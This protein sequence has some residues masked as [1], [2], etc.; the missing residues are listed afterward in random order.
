MESDKTQSPSIIV[1]DDGPEIQLDIP[2]PSTSTTRIDT[3]PLYG[4]IKD[5]PNII[6][7]S[8]ISVP[9]SCT[10]PDRSIHP[11]FA[12]K[13]KIPYTSNLPSPGI[14]SQS[15]VFFSNALPPY[16]D[17][18]LQHVRGPQTAFKA[19]STLYP[20]RPSRPPNAPIH[21]SRS[22]FFLRSDATSHAGTLLSYR[23]KKSSSDHN[24]RPSDIPEDIKSSH[25]AVARLVNLQPGDIPLSRRPWAEKWRPSCAQEVLGNERNATYLRDWLRALELQIEDN[26][27]LPVPNASSQDN[28]KGNSKNKNISRG[29]KRP[30]V[31]RKVDKKR[32]KKMRLDS[33]EEEDDWIVY[34]DEEYGGDRQNDFNQF[35][36]YKELLMNYQLPNSPSSSIQGHSQQMPV[37]TT[38][39]FS[40]LGQLHNTILLVG[41]S[42][43]GKTASIYA[44]ARELGWEVFEVYPGIGRRNATSLDNLIGEVGKNHLVVQSH[45][46]SHICDG[47]AKFFSASKGKLQSA[48]N[49]EIIVGYSPRK[50]GGNEATE[51]DAQYY[52]TE[53]RTIRQSLI[54][55][56]EVDI[57][58]KEDANFWSTMIKIIEECKR[59]IIFTCNGRFHFRHF[60]FLF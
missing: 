47:T 23:V 15:P 14:K 28:S 45:I 50:R 39:R 19:P 9:P 60:R 3:A 46:Q 38:K 11:F 21:E 41:P 48:I 54:L 36:E 7:S 20:T 59:P 16:P 27:T 22:Y 57:L 12:P 49:E 30:R 43:C 58:F 55:L 6:S 26:N 40:G 33:D 44:C 10:K 53:T 56:E 4:K 13:R 32:R 37:E 52:D 18:T 34:S 25:P 51:Q 35:E 29:T 2:A 24:T 1:L 8:P 42:G 31:I 17:Q 5:N